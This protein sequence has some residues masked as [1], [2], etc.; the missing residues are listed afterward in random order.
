[1]ETGTERIFFVRG[2]NTVTQPKLNLELSSGG[3]GRPRI[4]TLIQR[5][6]GQSERWRQRIRT[7]WNVLRRMVCTFEWW[8]TRAGQGLWTVQYHKTVISNY[9]WRKLI[10]LSFFIVISA[11]I[12]CDYGL[13]AVNIS[14]YDNNHQNQKHRNNFSLNVV[15]LLG[16]QLKKKRDKVVLKTEDPTLDINLYNSIVHRLIKETRMVQHVCLFSVLLNC[17]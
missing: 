3:K 17:R 16:L 8:W 6:L 2:S 12:D 4:P 14:S 13:T 10:K 1:M 15:T 5:G 11:D 9:L 7:D